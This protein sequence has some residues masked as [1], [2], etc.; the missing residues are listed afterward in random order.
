MNG[1]HCPN[2]GRLYEQLQIA[3]RRIDGLVKRLAEVHP[4]SSRPITAHAPNGRKY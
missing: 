2:C 4:A 1:Q 3:Q